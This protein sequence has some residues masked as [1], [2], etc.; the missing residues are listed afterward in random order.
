MPWSPP[1]AIGMEDLAEAR[2][3][4]PVY[5]AYLTPAPAPWVSGRIATLMA[6]YYTPDMPQALGAAVFGDW[7]DILDDLPAHAI[8]EAAK[9]WLRTETRRRPGPGDIRDL[10]MRLVGDEMKILERLRK[11]AVMGERQNS[12]TAGVISILGRGR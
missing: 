3:M 8:Q 4:I 1:V 10:A 6:H 11:I 7:I 2:R 9:K 12:P 5:E